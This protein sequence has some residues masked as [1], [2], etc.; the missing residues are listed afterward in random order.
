MFENARGG[1][2][3][4]ARLSSTTI[5]DAALTALEDVGLGGLTIRVVAA[6]LGTAPSALYWHVKDK[7]QLLDRMA[8]AMLR[9]MVE[10]AGWDAAP[11]DWRGFSRAAAHGLRRC[12]LAHRDGARVFSGSYLTDDDLLGTMEVPL[13][14]FTTG[15]F[16]LHEAVWNWQALQAYVVGFVIEEQGVARHESRPAD[17]FDAEHRTARLDAER[18]PLTAAASE[19]LFAR[20][21]DRFAH[22]LELLLRGMARQTTG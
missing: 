12:L 15:G 16:A 1:S 5:T 10:Q 14:R 17:A 13:Q 19:H 8:T 6:Q 18:F 9:E 3:P 11:Q 4:K 21:D 7:Q 2:V 22:G 20:A